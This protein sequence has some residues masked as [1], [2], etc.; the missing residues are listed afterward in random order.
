M[1]D[2]PVG[3]HPEALAEAEAAAAWY[4]KRGLRAAELFVSELGKAIEAI[5]R[6]VEC[7]EAVNRGMSESVLETPKRR[8]AATVSAAVDSVPV[9][10]A[11]HRA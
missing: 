8:L 1:S 11:E 5:S 4:R 7:L 2:K 9:D 6:A 3:F 10:A